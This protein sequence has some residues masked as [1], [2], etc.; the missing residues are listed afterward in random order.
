MT[1]TRRLDLK[2]GLFF[3]HTDPDLR[4]FFKDKDLISCLGAL[5]RIGPY[6]YLRVE[7]QIASSHAQSNFGALAE[8][9]LLRF[10]LMNGE[11]VSL[12]NLK[13]NSGRI[14]PYSGYTVFSGQYA[15]GKK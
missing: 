13:T 12:Y 1:G 5:S 10:K 9:S 6:V 4:P 8:G 7:F 11:Y 14:D 15:L 3:S 2:P